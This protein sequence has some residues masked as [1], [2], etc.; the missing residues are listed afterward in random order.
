MQ[1]LM[2]DTPLLLTGIL[3]HALRATPNQEIVTNLVEGGIHRYTYAEAG[4][5]IAKLANALTRMGIKKGDRVGV[6]GWNTHRQLELYY[7]TAGIGAVCHTINPRLGPE[8]AGYVM[9]HAQDKVVFFDATFAPLAEGLAPHLPQVETFVAMTPEGA[10]ISVGGK[11]VDTYEGLIAKEEDSYDW[12]DLDE[13]TAC[14]L[15]Y[16]SG[17]TGKPKGVL[18]THRALV[19][20]TLV[21]S[22]PTSFGTTPDD[23]ILPVV[24]MFH[25]NAWGVPY[26]AL[27]GGLKLVLPGPGMDGETLYKLMEEEKVTYS[28]GVPTV[29][30][31]LLAYVEGNKLSF[32]TLKY[33]LVGGSALSARIIQGFEALGVRTR[34]GWGMTEMSPTGTVNAEEP[35]FYDLPKDERITLQLRQG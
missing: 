19:L 2:M 28:L 8:N 11:P 35:G 4:A 13:N 23:V 9:N 31:N 33:S 7:A 24:P 34:Q 14:A 27:L 21:T 18:Y 22:L 20:H 5:R 15:C 3:R 30:L 26:T 25:V 32:S 10:G 1:G 6:I 16:T 12:P 17:T 29:W